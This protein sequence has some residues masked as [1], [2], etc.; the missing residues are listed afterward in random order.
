VTEAMT[1]WSTGIISGRHAWAPGLYTLTIDANPEPFVAGQFFNMGLPMGDQFVRR[2]YS[3]ASA[4]GQPLEFFITRVED[5]SLSPQLADLEVGGQIWVEPRARGF[6]TLDYVPPAAELWLI[7]TGTGLGPFVSMLRAGALFDRFERVVLVHGARVASHL[8][9]AS[10]LEQ[11]AAARAG[12]LV[13]V[14]VVSREVV[15]GALRGRVT[16]ALRDGRLEAR[17]GTSLDPE[18]SHVMLCGN[19]AMIEEMMAAFEGRGLRRHRVRKPGHVT[20]EKYW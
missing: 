8:A 1:G 7:A 6:F 20:F 16:D 2:S 10:E 15:E 12:R 9:Y 13:R 19:P 17:A 3:A 5:G 14:P 11:L 18:R 4:P